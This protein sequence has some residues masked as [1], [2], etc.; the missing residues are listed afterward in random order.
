MGPNAAATALAPGP[1]P[2]AA[3]PPPGTTGPA[4]CPNCGAPRLGAYCHDCGQHHLA[5]RLQLRQ[6]W[7]EFVERFL[8]LEQGL[9][10]TVLALTLQPGAAIRDYVQGHRRKYANPFSY[11]LIGSAVSLLLFGLAE[12]RFGPMIESMLEMSRPLFTDRQFDLYRQFTEASIQQQAFMWLLI[13]FPFAG[14]L[15]AFFDDRGV[16]IAETFVFTLFVFGHTLL[17]DALICT[18][19]VF[20]SNH[21]ALHLL[22]TFGTLM[23][24][25]GY[26]AVGFFGRRRW[27]AFKAVLALFVAYGFISTVTSTALVVVLKLFF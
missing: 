24:V 11:F 9:F 14:L 15:R 21:F 22:L 27:T 25:C 18:P 12:G 7:D 17:L 10:H 3:G 2:L 13:A 5:T 19:I 6:L 23:V 1:A 8:N 20:I 16:N 4:S 26:A